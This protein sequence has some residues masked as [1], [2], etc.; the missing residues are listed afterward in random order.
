MPRTIAVRVGYVPPPAWQANP[1]D[2]VGLLDAVV[3]MVAATRTVTEAVGLTDSATADLVTDGAV[4]G[5][6]F[7]GTF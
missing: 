2:G 1:A 4:F 7:G 6:N 5:G 3:Q